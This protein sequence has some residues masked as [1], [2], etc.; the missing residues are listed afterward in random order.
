METPSN[1]HVDPV[2]VHTKG[3]LVRAV[4]EGT[5]SALRK[6][7]ADWR[8]ERNAAPG[9]GWITNE[10]AMVLLGL[11]RPTLARYRASGKLAYSRVG[12]S[13]YYRLVDVESLLESGLQNH[14][15]TAATT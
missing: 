12:S 2:I 14:G 1:I 10:K 7:R 15:T 3:S 9:F 5:E 8:R 13:V 11:S 4:E 6:A